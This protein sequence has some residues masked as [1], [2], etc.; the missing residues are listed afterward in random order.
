LSLI[1]ATN[2]VEVNDLTL[3]LHPAVAAMLYSLDL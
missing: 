1:V 3:Q 2:V